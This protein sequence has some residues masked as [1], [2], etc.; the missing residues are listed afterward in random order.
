MATSPLLRVMADESLTRHRGWRPWARQKKMGDGRF[1]G[2][3]DKILLLM[4]N[5]KLLLLPSLKESINHKTSNIMPCFC[6]DNRK[7]TN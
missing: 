5:L 3:L 4:K 1:M 7:K 2:K 6:A